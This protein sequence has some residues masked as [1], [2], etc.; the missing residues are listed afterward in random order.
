MSKGIYRQG[1]VFMVPLT[2]VPLDIPEERDGDI[3]LAHGEVTG[4]AHRIKDTQARTFNIDGRRYL[5]TDRPTD[6]T[7]EEHATI[8]LPQ[9][10]YEIR[11]QREYTPE[12]IRN[13]MD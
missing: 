7:H 12:S 4:H 6:V 2:E 10:R 3:I 9:G 8:T 13:V 5:I 11:I 1:D